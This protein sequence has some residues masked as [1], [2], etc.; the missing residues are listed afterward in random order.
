MLNKVK[1]IK[2]DQESCRLPT[3]MALFFCNDIITLAVKSLLTSFNL[4]IN[5]VAKKRQ[6][7]NKTDN[8]FCFFVN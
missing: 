5:I 3:L 2:S 7:V 4:C 8:L 6:I 1:N